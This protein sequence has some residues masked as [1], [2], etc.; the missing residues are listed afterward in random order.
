VAVLRVALQMALGILLTLGL[1]LLLRMWSPPSRRERG[2][3]DA[4][5]GAA[6][7]AFGPASMLGFCWVTRAPG[8]RGAAIAIGRAVVWVALLVVMVT[9]IDVGFV[10]R[11]GTLRERSEAISATA[12]APGPRAAPS[13]QRERQ[14]DV[15]RHDRDPPR[16]TR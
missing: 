15:R 6:L 9:L 2:W 1:Q 16:S 13:P 5:W 3:N 8:T 11:Y 7:Y 10:G 14:R 12:P 4:T